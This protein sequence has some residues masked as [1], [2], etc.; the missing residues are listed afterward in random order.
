MVGCTFSRTLHLLPSSPSEC[1]E[2][3][4]GLRSMGT[5]GLPSP[6]HLLC[7]Q[8]PANLLCLLATQVWLSRGAEFQV[9]WR[10]ALPSATYLLLRV[11]YRFPLLSAK[12]FWCCWVD[13]CS[14][15]G[16]NEPSWGPFWL[17]GYRSG[18]TRSQSPSSF[19]W[20]DR[21]YPTSIS[22]LQLWGPKPI[23]SSYHS[24]GFSFDCLL[25]FQGLQ[26]YLTGRNGSCQIRNPKRFK[27]SHY[28]LML[29]LLHQTRQI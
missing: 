25:D 24:S 22:F 2:E 13:S 23:C 1:K 19:A 9:Q 26:S 12:L 27:K 14:V 5:T 8:N 4:Q 28:P 16:R 7:W 10:R 29:L 3:A 15:L 20:E 6:G 17:L 18:C 21:R 11:S